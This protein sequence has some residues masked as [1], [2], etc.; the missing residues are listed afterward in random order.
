MLLCKI[1]S[2][3]KRLFV[4]IFSHGQVLDISYNNLS[5]DDLL[6]LGLM[7]RLRVLHLTGNNFSNLPPDLAMPYLSREK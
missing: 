6:T 5:Q 7:A 1:F 3:S 2:L 4:S